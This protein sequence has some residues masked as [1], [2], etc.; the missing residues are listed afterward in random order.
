[1]Q[2]NS[3]WWTRPP[4]HTRSSCQ[5]EWTGWRSDSHTWRKTRWGR[6]RRGRWRI[7]GWG[8]G[9]DRWTWWS[10]SWRVEHHRQS[11]PERGRGNQNRRRERSGRKWIG[12]T[13]PVCRHL[14]FRLIHNSY[15]QHTVCER[16]QTRQE[17]LYQRCHK[18]LVMRLIHSHHSSA[19]LQYIWQTAALPFQKCDEVKAT[20][21][22]LT[23]NKKSPSPLRCTEQYNHIDREVQHNE[24]W[25]P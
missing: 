25:D 14:F 24:V 23:S 4:S 16:Y 10:C 6:R 21:S 12:W 13:A 8:I 5:S 22:S 1:M 19:S 11:P 15:S 20:Q 18:C 17:D 7:G 9:R 3:W 2:G